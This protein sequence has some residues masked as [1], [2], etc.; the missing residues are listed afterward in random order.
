[1]PTVAN[2]QDLKKSFGPRV[3]FAGVSFAV[4]EGEK[5]GFVGVNGSG[6]STLFRIVAGVEGSEGGTL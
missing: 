5:V 1:M 6:K 3:I 4:D 2:V